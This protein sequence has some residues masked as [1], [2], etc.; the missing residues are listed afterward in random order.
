MPLSIN[1]GPRVTLLVPICLPHELASKEFGMLGSNYLKHVADPSLI[2]G[3]F[4]THV[5]VQGVPGKKLRTKPKQDP[6]PARPIRVA[7]AA[8]SFPDSRRAEGH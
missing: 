8:A 5:V 6:Q 2:T 1:G 3:D 4:A 7:A